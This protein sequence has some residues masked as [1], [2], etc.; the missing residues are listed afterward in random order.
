MS[1]SKHVSYAGIYLTKTDTDLPDGFTNDFEKYTNFQPL[2]AGGNGELVA[3]YDTNLGRN[4][5]IKKL[6]AAQEDNARA[7]RRLLREA[8]VTAQLSHP[9]TAPVYEIGRTDQG[10][11]YF[12]MKKIEGQNLFRILSAIANDEQGAREQYPLSDLVY[13]FSQVCNCL[14]YAHS[15]GVIHRDIKPENILVGRFGDVHLIDWGVAKV[16]G[17]PH[18]GPEEDTAELEA[19]VTEAGKR[20]GTPLYMSPEQINDRPVDER[21]DVFSMGVLLYEILVLTVPFQGATVESTFKKINLDTPPAPSKAAEHFS[22]P[23]EFDEVC[24]KAMNKKPNMRYQSMMEMAQA[25]LKAQAA[26]H[27]DE[28]I[29]QEE[30]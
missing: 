14:A 24:A 6:P 2:G 11:L 19:R 28:H 18:E 17:M 15:R 8:R 16:W 27:A 3:C 29:E 21:S 22:V 26:L 1:D 20:P 13:I 25:V 30:E 23:T 4:V 5:V 9:A 10:H 12:A 7:R